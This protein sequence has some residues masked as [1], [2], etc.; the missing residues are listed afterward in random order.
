[1]KNTFRQGILKIVTLLW[2]MISTLFAGGQENFG[3][4]GIH[5]DDPLK[6][7]P[8]FSL[9]TQ[10]F[11]EDTN[12]SLHNSLFILSAGTLGYLTHK[13]KKQSKRSLIIILL[14]V[15]LLGIT[16]YA[17]DDR[18]PHTIKT[19]HVTFSP[20]TPAQTDIIPLGIVTFSENDILHVF[21]GGN[22]SIQPRYLGVLTNGSTPGGTPV[23][24]GDIHPWKCGEKLSFFY[25]GDNTVNND[26]TTIID[27]SNQIYAGEITPENDLKNIGDHYLIARFQVIA[28]DDAVTKSF[29]GQL[30][31]MM[32]L[33]VFD[34]SDFNDGTDIGISGG[35]NL[36]NMMKI[37]LDG[38]IE[39]HVAG[40]NTSMD[41]QSG[42]IIIGKGSS[43]KYV[44][45]LPKTETEEAKV[46][47]IF[48]T[49]KKTSPAGLV[50]SIHKN[51]FIGYVDG[52]VNPITIFAVNCP[53][54]TP[55]C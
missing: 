33:A 7:E 23:F 50:L 14:C 13:N 52:S 34:V 35:K 42:H 39:Y 49:D 4:P 36:N 37:N 15:V 44:A 12:V 1:M 51:D 17:K 41:N 28:R 22:G 38:S 47:L 3:H 46:S 18:S 10:N 27:F 53:D 54:D 45:L 2:L 30:K 5:D 25:L 24:T 20:S 55:C 6:P 16:G 26:G 32:A 40:I 48:T 29:S 43:N 31:N 21:A 8:L 9:T 19:V 11:G